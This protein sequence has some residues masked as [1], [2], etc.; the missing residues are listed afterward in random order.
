M[1]YTTLFN[2]VVLTENRKISKLKRVGQEVLE[3]G[4]NSEIELERVGQKMDRSTER[5]FSNLTNIFKFYI[6]HIFKIHLNRGSLE[7]RK[8]F[9]N[10]GRANLE[11]GTIVSLIQIS[12]E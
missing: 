10:V 12:G 9:Q 11:M 2:Y 6:L 7:D 1:L 3:R 8:F 4:A 5:R